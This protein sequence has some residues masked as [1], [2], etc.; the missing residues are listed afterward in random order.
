MKKIYKFSLLICVL[1]ST[2]SLVSCMKNYKIVFELNGGTMEEASEMECEVGTEY[3][4][5]TPSKDGYAF[6]GWYED[7]NFS[8]DSVS[9]VKISNWIDKKDITLYAKF[10]KL[11]NVKY[12]TSGGTTT[13]PTKVRIDETVNLSEASNQ[14]VVFD[15]WYTDSGFTNKVTQLVNP[16]NDVVLYAKYFTAYYI[17]YELDGGINHTA[18]PTN[19]AAE[20][21]ATLFAPHRDGYDFV[22]WVDEEGNDILGIPVGTIGNIRIKASWKPA[23]YSISWNLDG[24]SVSEEMPTSYIYGTGI[25]NIYD[26]SMPERNTDLF[27]GW[28]MN[29]KGK[30]VRVENIGKD[31]FGN[32]E[33]K[34]KWY[35][36]NEI[37]QEP[38]WGQSGSSDDTAYNSSDSSAIVIEIPEELKPLAQKGILGITVSAEFEVSVRINGDA[39]AHAEAGL[40]L[41]GSRYSVCSSSSTGK[42]YF[43]LGTGPYWGAWGYDTDVVTKTVKVDG[44]SNIKIG[45]FYSMSNN[46]INVLVETELEYACKWISYSFCIIE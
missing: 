5:P 39:T 11:I 29:V 40:C 28:Y 20:K 38:S 8:G 36:S 23:T 42:G 21:G 19:Y 15:A 45:Y 16:Q 1:L 17:T 33:L 27:M 46:K 7:K 31:V 35:I 13:N 3:T 25:S 6:D 24:G 41:N 44:A 30:E 12:E 4:L 43:L 32:I 9:T 37:K 18:N 14:G 26:F 2:L 10:V 22:G 34:A